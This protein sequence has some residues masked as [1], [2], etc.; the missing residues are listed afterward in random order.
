[1][2]DHAASRAKRLAGVSPIERR[3]GH[4]RLARALASQTERWRSHGLAGPPWRRRL[5]DMS[6]LT[7]CACHELELGKSGSGPKYLFE[8]LALGQFVDE[9]V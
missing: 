2:M 4:H 3:V 5:T 1:M 9:F 6:G 8:G 7:V